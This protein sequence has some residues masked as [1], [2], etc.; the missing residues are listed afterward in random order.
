MRT[1]IA[2]KWFG[3]SLNE[4]A[5]EM[6]VDRDDLRDALAADLEFWIPTD[7]S[8]VNDDVLIV[9]ASPDELDVP[10]ALRGAIQRVHNSAAERITRSSSY[11]VTGDVYVAPRA[12]RAEDDDDQGGVS[13]GPE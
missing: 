11:E 9:C 1:D 4:V 10:D 2:E 6:D 7:R 12:L 8:F 3:P 5:T 13:G